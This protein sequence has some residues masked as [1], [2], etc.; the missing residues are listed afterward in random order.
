MDES[1]KK[2]WATKQ[3]YIALGTVMTTAASLRID[4]C[5]MEGFEAAAYQNF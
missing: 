2:E 1:S 5:A 3:A 4:S